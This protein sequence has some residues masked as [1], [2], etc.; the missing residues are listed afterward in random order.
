M[1][2]FEGIFIITTKNE[3]FYFTT[4]INDGDFNLHFIPLCAYEMESLHNEIERNIIKEGYF[5]EEEYPF[6]IH[7]FFLGFR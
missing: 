6:V 3:K 1:T 4:S 7:L 5:A 2:D